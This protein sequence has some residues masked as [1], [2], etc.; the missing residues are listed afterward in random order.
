MRWAEHV[1]QM[2]VT[3]NLCNILF[4][5]PEL[6]SSY[7]RPSCRWEDNGVDWIY[8]AQDRDQWQGL[9][10]TVMILSVSLEFKE[11]DYLSNC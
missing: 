2:I 4:G 7:G 11:F 9:V 5:K 10:N 3:R 6:R 8:L 1:A